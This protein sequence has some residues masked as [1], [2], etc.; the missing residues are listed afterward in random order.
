[1]S[2]QTGPGWNE[3][4]QILGDK[5]LPKWNEVQQ[6]FN[7]EW[8]KETVTLA[9]KVIQNTLKEIRSSRDLH[10]VYRQEQR[11]SGNY[12]NE[13]SKRPSL[14]Y[15]ERTNIWERCAR[16]RAVISLV[17]RLDGIQ[18]DEQKSRHGGMDKPT[19]ASKV[20]MAIINMAGSADLM[21]K[22][23][24][25]V[26]CSKVDCAK[27]DYGV[28]KTFAIFYVRVPAFMGLAGHQMWLPRLRE[29]TILD[30]KVTAYFLYSEGKETQAQRNA[31]SWR[32]TVYGV[33][34]TR[35]PTAM[36]ETD[37]DP[38]SDVAKSIAQSVLNYAKQSARRQIEDKDAGFFKTLALADQDP[39]A[40]PMAEI[41]QRF[42]LGSKT[43]D[44]FQKLCSGKPPIIWEGMAQLVAGGDGEVRDGKWCS[45][46]PGIAYK[47]YCPDQTAFNQNKFGGQHGHLD[48]YLGEMAL[49]FETWM[50]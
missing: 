47:L 46:A 3:I 4:N 38:E 31:S 49:T 44:C 40:V 9:N 6:T 34:M 16:C 18:I 29:S 26:V 7:P 37:Y 30:C 24:L 12:N 19:A 43:W 5:A 17:I 14:G 10:E 41:D 39:S 33:E 23:I 27:N 11:A 22:T 50:E 36:R 35:D 13:Y 1:M 2:T 28:T 21:G 15:L 8:T 42:L 25:D 45:K 32:A 48:L 20:K